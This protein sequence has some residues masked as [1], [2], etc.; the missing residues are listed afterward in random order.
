M[1]KELDVVVLAEDLPTC[2]LRA[3]DRGAVVLVLD[4]GA[5]YLVEFEGHEPVLLSAR[6]LS[7]GKSVGAVTPR[8]AAL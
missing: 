8:V 1:I 5:G 6:Q 4:Q 7:E 2:G 3:G